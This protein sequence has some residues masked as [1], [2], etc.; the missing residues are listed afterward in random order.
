M[1]LTEEKSQNPQ[2]DVF[3]ALRGCQLRSEQGTT[4]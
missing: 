2:E 1:V 3:L 4:I